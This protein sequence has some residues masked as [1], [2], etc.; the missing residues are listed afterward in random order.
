MIPLT[1]FGSQPRV[2][3]ICADGQH[4]FFCQRSRSGE[5]DGRCI[6]CYGGSS[7]TPAANRGSQQSSC[8]EAACCG[9]KRRAC[10]SDVPGFASQ[11]PC[12]PV[13]DKA[14]FLSVPKS[15]LEL[16]RVDAAPL[17]VAFEPFAAIDRGTVVDFH[18]GE[19]LPPPDI[20]IEFGVLLI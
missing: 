20:V 14:T 1:I 9:C 2:A 10:D 8:G 17:F 6:C 7:E 15:S 13:L 19:L 5:V 3:C 18:R 11:R 16:A 12:R 4:K